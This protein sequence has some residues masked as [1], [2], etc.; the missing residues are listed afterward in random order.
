MHF[1]SLLLTIHPILLDLIILIIVIRNIK[2]KF[3]YDFWNGFFGT[4]ASRFVYILLIL[5]KY[6]IVHNALLIQCSQHSQLFVSGGT[7]KR[8]LYCLCCSIKYPW[9][10]VNDF[11]S[12]GCNHIL[13]HTPSNFCLCFYEDAHQTSV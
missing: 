2:L 13:L 5:L 11:Q 12:C 10:E 4:L 3:F 1:L 8:I 6:F 9:I 7:H